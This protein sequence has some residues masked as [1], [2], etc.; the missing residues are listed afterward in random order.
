M[1]DGFAR[2]TF[3]YSHQAGAVATTQIKAN[4]GVLR[5]ITFNTVGATPGTVTLADNT[6][7]NSTTNPIAIVVPTASV[8]ATTY[9]Y[10]IGFVN[11]LT[12]TN[13][14][15]TTADVTISYM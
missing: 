8:N 4:P 5:G 7:P 2:P 14:G 6:V 13:S 10:D 9:Q 3:K 11:G 1:A 15:G 12:Y